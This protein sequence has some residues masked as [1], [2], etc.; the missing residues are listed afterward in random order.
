MSPSTPVV[1][2]IQNRRGS[3]RAYA[4]QE[5]RGGW[6]TCIDTYL[7]RFIE[8]QTSVFLATARC[9]GRPYIQT[10]VALPAFGR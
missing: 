9:P 3:R 6:A 4:M 7:K 5:E 1:K 8:S 10:V 2:A